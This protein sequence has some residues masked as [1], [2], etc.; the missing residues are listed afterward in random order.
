MKP[1]NWT[2]VT[3][4]PIKDEIQSP[5]DSGIATNGSKQ[6]PVSGTR[7]ANVWIPV[8]AGLFM[9]ALTV[10]AIVVPRLRL[11]HLLQALIYVAVILLTRRNN[12]LG[13]GAGITIAAIWNSLN[14][15][16]THL[17]Q[18]G[19]RE[20]WSLLLTGH[21]RRPDTM[22]V[23]LGG[24]AHF[25]LIIACVAA[26]LQLHPGKKEWGQFVAGGVLVLAY[27]ALIIVAAAPR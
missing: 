16:V 17:F 24:V 22:M 9:V 6:I 19:A 8:G 20:F 7:W 10:S 4:P 12:A 13:F 27:F 23:T 5:G 2:F 15:F 14:L 3:P 18:A 25:I 1:I 21:L 26:F 11:L